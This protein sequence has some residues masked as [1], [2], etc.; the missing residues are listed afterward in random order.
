MA[1]PFTQ[2]D[3]AQA[4]ADRIATLEA[5][6]AAALRIINREEVG[7][8]KEE[9][10][11]LAIERATAQENEVHTIALEMGVHGRLSNILKYESG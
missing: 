5:R 2:E 7:S 3:L 11:R 8:P 6:V 10:A 4:L 1:R 9:A